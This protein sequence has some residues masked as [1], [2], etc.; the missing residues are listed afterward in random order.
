MRRRQITE[1]TLLNYK[2]VTTM[3]TFAAKVEGGSLRPDAVHLRSKAIGG[4][5]LVNRA[6][7]QPRPSGRERAAQSFRFETLR[8]FRGCTAEVAHPKKDGF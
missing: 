5:H 6:W 1:N 2:F 8:L 4:E 3:D 7:L